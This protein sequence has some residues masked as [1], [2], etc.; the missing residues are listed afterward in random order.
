MVEDMQAALPGVTVKLTVVGGRGLAAS[1]MLEL[2]RTVLKGQH[3]TLV[4]WQTGTV[5]AVRSLV[6]A[7]FHDVLTE[8]ID[9]IQAQGG[10]ILLVDPQFSRFLRA[11]ADIDPYE[12]VF[13]E[14]AARPGV[15]A[16]R[17]FDLMR[18]WA[19]SGELDLEHVAKNDRVPTL[20]KLHGC[21]GTALGRLVLAASGVS[22]PPPR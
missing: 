10:D 20:D 5:E 22:P 16:F 14:E 9:A 11:N 19:E 13:R 2:L 7:D 3:F 21:L 18:E 6:A 8:G 1:E 15:I 17:R 12:E 4:L